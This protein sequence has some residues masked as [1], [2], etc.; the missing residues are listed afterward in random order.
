MRYVIREAPYSPD[1]RTRF[2][3]VT[4][5]TWPVTGI[6]EAASFRNAAAQF[7]TAGC[8]IELRNAWDRF[9]VY[10]AREDRK[11]ILVERS[12]RYANHRPAPQPEPA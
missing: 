5:I 6:A 9:A 8:T 4:S 1:G 2:N 11:I 12:P 10:D 3:A 7:V